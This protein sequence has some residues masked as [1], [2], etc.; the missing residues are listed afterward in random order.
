MLYKNIFENKNEE[1]IIQ[2]I[3]K[4]EISTLDDDN[5]TILIVMCYLNINNII[6]YILS[7]LKNK[8]LPGHYNK[9]G[10]TALNFL[11]KNKNEYMCI[12]LLSFD[13][14]Y[15]TINHPDIYGCNSFINSVGMNLEYICDLMMDYKNL[16]IN[17]LTSC[18]TDALMYSIYEKNYNI[19]EKILKHPNL[20]LNKINCNFATS[21]GTASKLNS[22]LFFKIL[23]KMKEKKNTQKNSICKKRNG[24]EFSFFQSGSPETGSIENVLPVLENKTKNIYVLKNYK[25]NDFSIIK[26]IFYLNLLHSNHVVKIEGIILNLNKYI[27]LEPM[28]INY[29]ELYSKIH[30]FEYFKQ[31]IEC[32]NYC[33]SYGIMHNDLKNSNIMIDQYGKLKFIDFG[34]SQI[35][36]YPAS[37]KTLN[38]YK[39]T[40]YIQPEDSNLK[41]RPSYVSDIYS[42]GVT[43][44]NSILGTK[45]ENYY[46][47]EK[48]F[49]N[50]VLLPNND[51]DKIKMM[52]T[53]EID[54]YDL[55][56]KMIEKNSKNRI[57]AK[58]ILQ[59]LSCTVIQDTQKIEKKSCTKTEEKYDFYEDYFHYE[60]FE[61]ELEYFE[62]I[63]I[64]YLSSKIK[65][66]NNKHTNFLNGILQI[67][68]KHK[69]HIDTLINSICL[70]NFNFINIKNDIQ[71]MM[72]IYITFYEIIF[73]GYPIHDVENKFCKYMNQPNRANEFIDK[74][75]QFFD[76]NMLSVPVIPILHNVEY[77]CIK[78]G[79]NCKILWNF[80]VKCIIKYVI[81]R[82]ENEETQ[83]YAL[84]CT[85]YL[86]YLERNNM[87]SEHFA[88][89]NLVSNYI[90]IKEFINSNIEID[91]N[92]IE[93][94]K[95]CCF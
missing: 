90:S 13:E 36:L 69:F 73:S 29:Y 23:E 3:E 11:V 27:I 76:N 17:Y 9:F 57:S 84:F 92:L 54:F 59:I 43:V 39:T 12:L 33:S 49:G 75:K 95:Y 31:L 8:S 62:E 79:D 63:H 89:K 93:L 87:S 64:S 94:K 14:T 58:K 85:F 32:A 21:L 30:F 20:I 82:E 16:D 34:L 22:K 88:D 38:I 61:Y 72:L 52:N 68:K 77:I 18:G 4:N 81:F 67:V 19:S 50:N 66:G 7:N 53:N 1:E 47:S 42:I 2:Y 24:N 91:E 83:V 55:I 80:L 74:F 44:L 40:P 5:N 71:M 26:E 41:N 51:I 28:I 10:Q 65:I 37:K 86:I 78:Y 46:F 45:Y 35:C 56:C 6:K 70:M 25:K 48:L 60:Q 15:L